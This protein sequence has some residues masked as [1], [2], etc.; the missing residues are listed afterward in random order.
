VIRSKWTAIGKPMPIALAVGVEPGL[1][2]VGGMPL[3]EGAD[4]SHFLGALFG[5]GLELVPAETVDLLVP[6]TAEMIIEGY[7][8]LDETVMEGP[9]N[10]FPGYN[11]YEASPSNCSPSPRSRTGTGPSSRSSRL[12]RR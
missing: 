11:A 1:P 9:M 4:E 7:I 3:P 5:E 2:F 6:A 10:E 8:S 12:G